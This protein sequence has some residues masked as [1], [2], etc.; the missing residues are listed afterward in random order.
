MAMDLIPWEVIST[1]ENRLSLFQKRE[2]YQK[3]RRIK[4]LGVDYGVLPNQR[5][6]LRKLFLVYST[7]MNKIFCTGKHD[8]QENFLDRQKDAMDYFDLVLGLLETDNNVPNNY[9]IRDE[10]LPL[11]EDSKKIFLEQSPSLKLPDNKFQFKLVNG[12]R[13]RIDVIWKFIALWLAKKKTE[14]YKE[15]YC[16]KDYTMFHFKQFFNSLFFYILKS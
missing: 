12:D 14:H 13:N 3:Q 1:S 8:L 10:N 15:I 16:C 7:L 5:F 9:L 6:N 11:N 2:L 4:K